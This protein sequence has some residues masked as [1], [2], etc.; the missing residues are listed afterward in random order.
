MIN[1]NLCAF[2]LIGLAA[3]GVQA[4]EY[5]QDTMAMGSGTEA[6]APDTTM[7]AATDP[8]V[9]D[10]MATATEAAPAASDTAAAAMTSTYTCPDGTSVPSA[11]SRC[12]DD[13]WYLSPFG[14]F[15]QPGGDRKAFG[16][17][18]GGMGIGKMINEWLNL[19]VR[20]L[21]MNYS[22]NIRAVGGQTD[23]TGGT[24][25]ALFFFDRDVFSPYW[26][27]A[28]GGVNE[29]WRS[30]HGFGNQSAQFLFQTGVGATVELADNFLLRADVRYQLQTAN[31]RTVTNPLTGNGRTFGND[32]FNDLV[33]NAGFVIPLGEKPVPVAAAAPAAVDD[34]STKDS[35]GD[36]VNDCDDKCPGTMKGAKVDEYG[37]LVRIELRGVN[38]HYDSAE[39]TETAKGILDEVST[40]LIASGETKDIEVQG[41]TS[42]EGTDQYNMKLSQR[43]AAS[44][45][46]YLKMKGVP[47]NLYPK[48]YGEMYPKVSPD[49]TEEERSV[50]RR[51]ELV[52]MGE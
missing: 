3:S 29:S 45:V 17:W 37:C 39:L 9:A 16:G 33:V 26:V 51:V 20:G 28:V 12:V 22:N 24:V 42:T 38:F 14:T 41:H 4:A 10:P 50:N 27:A 44:V 40:G 34:C 49:R 30:A 8:A 52:W 48:G 18:G 43:R 7:T 31:S 25:D 19:E 35:D 2:A 1:K 15:M 21:W 5:G 32:V 46:D 6:V 23:L 11:D 36:G 47:N 13:R